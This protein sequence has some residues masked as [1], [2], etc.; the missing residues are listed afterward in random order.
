MYGTALGSTTIQNLFS[1]GLPNSNPAVRSMQFNFNEDARSALALNQSGVA[2]FDFD[3]SPPSRFRIKSLPGKGSLY[4]NNVP[5]ST[6]NFPVTN[7]A[8]LSYQADADDFS[9]SGPVCSSAYSTFDFDSSDGICDSS[10][11]AVD[12]ANCNSPSTA[13]ATICVSEVNDAPILTTSPTSVTVFAESPNANAFTLSCRDKDANVSALG[14]ARVRIISQSNS[15]LGTVLVN[16]TGN[17]LCTGGLTIAQQN[18]VTVNVGQ[19]VDASVKFCYNASATALTTVDVGTDIITYQCEDKNGSFTQGTIAVNIKNALVGGCGTPLTSPAQWVAGVKCTEA[20]VEDNKIYVR[21]NG[22]DAVPSH[23]P[24]RRFWRIDT[25]PPASTGTLYLLNGSPVIAGQDIA[26]DRATNFTGVYGNFTTI[27]G[28]LTLEFRPAKDYFNAICRLDKS[29]FVNDVRGRGG[30]ANSPPYRYTDAFD[31][32][33]HGCDVTSNPTGCPLTFGFS[34]GYNDSTNS[35]LYGPSFTNGFEITVLGVNDGVDNAQ[36][37]APSNVSMSKTSTEYFV[38]N[39]TLDPLLYSDPDGDTFRIGFY[40]AVLGTRASLRVRSFVNPDFFPGQPRVTFID[41]GDCLE[42]GVTRCK[43]QGKAYLSD[44]NRLFRQLSLSTA[45]SGGNDTLA[46]VVYDEVSR[47][48]EFQ[49]DASFF[50][51]DSGNNASTSTLLVFGRGSSGNDNYNLLSA[52]L[53]SGI[54]AGLFFIAMS[55]LACIGCVLSRAKRGEEAAVWVV[56]NLLCTDVE[57]RTHPDLSKMA[58]GGRKSLEAAIHAEHTRLAR[59]VCC[60]LFMR[61]SCPCMVKFDATELKVP[62]EEV[63]LEEAVN[64]TKKRI[65]SLHRPKGSPNAG[66]AAPAAKDPDVED[67]VQEDVLADDSIFDWERHL[68]DKTARVFYYNVKTHESRWTPPTVKVHEQRKIADR[69]SIKSEALFQPKPPQAPKG[70]GSTAD[71]GDAD[72]VKK[73]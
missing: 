60:A 1:A 32:G 19:N 50:T 52:A 28:N 34:I 21:L 3:T 20:A 17:G 45:Q 16:S 72:R 12:A 53:W 26:A 71:D 11:T 67:V 29:A 38:G 47:P 58:A 73:T 68:D 43:F 46:V 5:V 64:Q 6:L 39:D 8:L 2:F 55:C 33:F 69:T 22:F 59:V 36:L 62:D 65:A 48:E 37:V 27:A 15:T 54:A 14:L 56:R 70:N 24:D 41:G 51:L 9:F 30:C 35:I 49:A 10:L 63:M 44:L 57:H 61:R 13:T 25:L 31:L 40:I 23:T 66:P 42:T 7:A 18:F 4:Y